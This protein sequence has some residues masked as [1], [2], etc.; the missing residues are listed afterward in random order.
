L[1]SAFSCKLAFF[2]VCPELAGFHDKAVATLVVAVQRAGILQELALFGV[3]LGGR[4]LQEFCDVPHPRSAPAT[5]SVDVEDYDVFIANVLH[6][7]GWRQ[8]ASWCLQD[9]PTV[10]MARH[11]VHSFFC[12]LYTSKVIQIC[13]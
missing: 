10:C 2:S 8:I 3:D 1:G 13:T 4:K 9:K 11:F 7:S 12:L 6:R 5:D